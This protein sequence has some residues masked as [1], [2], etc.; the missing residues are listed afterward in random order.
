MRI[1]TALTLG[2]VLI[3]LGF[4]VAPG[5]PWWWAEPAGEV[6]PELRPV[7]LILPPGEFWIGSGN[8]D[9]EAQDNEKPRHRVRF[10]QRF[11]LGRT[12]VT[13]AQWRAVMG[14][15]PS[16][17]K[18]NGDSRPVERVTWYAA[19]EYLNRLSKREGLNPCYVT[20]D[21]QGDPNEGGT[22][23]SPGG[24]FSFGSVAFIAGCTGYRLPT[25]AEWEY[26]ARA[27]ATTPRYGALDAIAWWNGNSS[28]ATHLVAGKQANPWFFFDLLGNVWEWTHSEERDE[29]VASAFEG[30]PT[31]AWATQGRVMRGCGWMS[32]SALCRAPQRRAM[33]SDAR[34][35]VMGF[36]P[37]RFLDRP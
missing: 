6:A 19:I 4:A 36:R 26:A 29:P 12:E 30:S 13:Q 33:V 7:M 17:F 11:A 15:N 37:A 5:L 34:D 32:G 35:R 14:G 31:L 28:D 24:G 16:F 27:G 1:G 2:I 8:E 20:S 23:T 22:E 10:P 3:A 21:D 9:P 25:E 18:E